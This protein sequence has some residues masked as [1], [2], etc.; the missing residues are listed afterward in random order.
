M[1]TKPAL[2][3]T[4]LEYATRADK[5]M[6]FGNHRAAAGLL[7][8]SIRA[9]FIGL[10]EERGLPYADDLIDLAKTLEADGSVRKRYYSSN[11]GA[12]KL[13]RDHAELDA[14]DP[15]IAKGAYATMRQFI[16]E[17]HGDF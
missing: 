8:Q 1:A 3:L 11:L 4:P 9:T 13:L 10:A 5:E 14:L 6:A 17:Q 12:G 7:W 2:E 15:C 16:V